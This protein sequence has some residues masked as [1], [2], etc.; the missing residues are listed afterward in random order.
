VHGLGG[1]HLN[2][3]GVAPRLAEHGRV[4]ALDLAG[5][6]LTRTEG[7]GTGVGSNRSLLDAFLR[8]LHLPPVV[9]AGNSMGGQ[10]SLIQ[11]AH[12]PQTVTAMILVDAAFPRARSVRAQ[13]A[14]KVAAVFALYANRRLGEWFV[15]SRS[16]RLGPEG[17]VREGLRISAADP[18][19]IDPALVAATIEMARHRQDYDDA[20]RAFLDAARSIFQAQVYPGRY[21]AL[22]RA[23]TAPALLIHGDRDGLVPVASAREAAA[24]HANWDLVVLE[25][26]GHIPQMEAPDQFMAAVDEWLDRG[27]ARETG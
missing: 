21:R 10:I 2:W 16:R 12:A 5:F 3:A 18:S 13:P 17:L 22:V 20:S 23:V 6:G 8:A 15:E 25:G 19:T 26:V 27:Q 24:T 11:A 4:L 7:R 14:A 1:S 9:L